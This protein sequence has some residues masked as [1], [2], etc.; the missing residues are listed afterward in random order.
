MLVNLA[1]LYWIVGFQAL[2]QVSLMCHTLQATPS[3]QPLPRPEQARTTERMDSP[4]PENLIQPLSRQPDVITEDWLS[5]QATEDWLSRQSDAPAAGV[6]RPSISITGPSGQVT[7]IEL[8]GMQDNGASA[9]VDETRARVSRARLARSLAAGGTTMGSTDALPATNESAE[10]LA[11]IPPSM[12][13]QQLE[14]LEGVCNEDKDNDELDKH[15]QPHSISIAG[16]SRQVT[17][18]EL[19]GM[20]D[21]GASASVDET[22][23]RVSRARLARSLL[24]TDAVPGIN[25]SA[26]PARIPPSMQGQQLVWLE[27]LCNEDTDNDDYDKQF[28]V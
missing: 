24:S 7:P 4:Q 25:E 14:W 16:P 20:Q 18:I 23:A 13:G 8:P 3:S 27:G 6:E 5:H 21:N 26:E 9:S 19:P 17:P 22:R 11:R 2:R 28:G 10:P 1:A 15:V 12:Q